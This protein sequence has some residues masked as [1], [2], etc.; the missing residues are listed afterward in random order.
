MFAKALRTNAH[1]VAGVGAFSLGI[2]GGLQRPATENASTHSALQEIALRLR[3]IEQ[4]LGLKS[5]EDAKPK[6][7]NYP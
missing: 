4:D 6:Y 1:I 3:A 5:P 7:N 2:A